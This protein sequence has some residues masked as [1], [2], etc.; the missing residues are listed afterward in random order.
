M[1]LV[2]EAKAPG[3]IL[4]IGG[5]SVLERPNISFVSA[6][7]AYVR[8]KAESLDNKVVLNAIPLK[9]RSE[10]TIDAD[11]RISIMNLPKELLLMKT[12]VEVSLRYASSLGTM[13]TGVSVTT[14]NDSQFSY[15]IASGKVAKS[16]L[17]SS[18]ALTVA[19]VKAVLGSQPVKYDSEIVHKLAQTAHSIATGKIGSGFDI[20]AA[21]YGSIIYTRYSPEIVKMLPAEYTNQQLRELIDSKWDYTAEPFS[22]PKQFKLLF[23]NFVGEAMITT[24]AIGSVSDFKAKDS[25]QY[26][27]LMAELNREN[28]AAIEALRRINKGDLASMGEFKRA[29]NAGRQ[30]LKKLGVLSSVSVEPDDCTELIESTNSNGAFVS[31]LPGAGGKDAIAAIYLTDQ[32]GAR[33]KQFWNARKELG[34]LNL[35]MI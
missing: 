27:S 23:A 24:K 11:G 21:T 10:G 15:T 6:V 12:S 20:A 9:M 32:D 5:Y 3:K 22:L 7:N 19:V 14:D 26:N 30:L 16:G 31:K 29:F 17:G 1:G 13:I 18:A 4:W 35:E 8:A 2:T 33:L 28:V 34:I 25:A